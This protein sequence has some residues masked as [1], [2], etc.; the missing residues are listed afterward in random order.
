[1]KKSS[2]AL[3]RLGS[4]L[5]PRNLRGVGIGLSIVKH[6]VDAHGGRVL[7]QSAPGKGSRFTIEWPFAES[8]NQVNNLINR[9]Q[10]RFHPFKLIYLK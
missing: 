8:N 9:S 3:Y 6:I 5:R 4:E 10:N 2:S 1:M 7:V